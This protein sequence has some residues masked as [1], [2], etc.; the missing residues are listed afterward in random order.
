M[1]GVSTFYSQGTDVTVLKGRLAT[2]YGAVKGYIPS[3][4]TITIPSSGR[5]IESTT[6]HPTAMWANGTDTAIA[7]TGTGG[8]HAAGGAMIR[9][10]SSLFVNNRRLRGKTFLVPLTVS[11]YS[12]DGT[13][14]SA[15]FG[16]LN[17]AAAAVPG[18]TSGLAIWSRKWGQWAAATTGEC[19]D[20]AVVLTS[21]RD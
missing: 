5:V 11:S 8:V 21:R 18:G 10:N 9:W 14:D 12:S 3:G 20:K 16:V 19:V 7:C 13:L 17:T 1:P 15:A 2:F 6:G 4:I